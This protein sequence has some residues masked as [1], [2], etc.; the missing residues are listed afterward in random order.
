MRFAAGDNDPKRYNKP[1]VSEVAAI[2]IGQDG[3]PPTNK[4]IV[5]YPRDENKHR[6]SEL[7][8]YV[9][10]MSY[11]L[12]FPRGFPEGWSEGLQHSHQ[13]RS[14]AGKRTRITLL[15]Y[16][17]HRLMR[18]TGE[19]ES[20]LP[21]AGGRLF[22]QYCVDA[23]CKAEGQRLQWLRYNQNALRAEEYGVLR[24]WVAT[25]SSRALPPAAHEAH[26]PGDTPMIGRPVILPSS[27]TG[28]DRAMRMNY[29]DAMAIVRKFGKPD[30][31]VTFT[32]NPKWPEIVNNLA[33][34]QDPINRPDLVARVFNLKLKALLK[35]IIEESVLGVV[36]AYTWTIEFQ[37][38]GLPQA[39]ILLIMR[40]CDKPR[41]PEDVD[42]AVAAEFPD[43][44]N[45]QQKGLSKSVSTSMVHGPCGMFNREMP[46]TSET[47]VCNKGFPAEFAEE[48]ILPVNK[49]P[50]YRRR[51]N[52]RFTEKRGCA[53]D[54]RWVV[55]YNPYLTKRFDAHITVQVFT[56]IRA[57]KYLYKH[58]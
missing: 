7:H 19:R 13:H 50:T 39:H 22:Q 6:V 34:G 21:H 56:S 54:N 38:R 55:P 48:T 16:Y 44:Q 26:G 17:S 9:D 43:D 42:R 30:Y 27:F 12:L 58:S 41:T 24:D 1:S 29:Q 37:K 33:E 15:Q 4:D 2:F 18:R 5:V 11:P 52:E 45:P 28:G 40:S 10:P 32:A 8:R 46:C 25:Q 47:G 20:I 49:Y 3:A 23:Y 53:L 14:S 36:V 51:D 31:F 35:E 57:A